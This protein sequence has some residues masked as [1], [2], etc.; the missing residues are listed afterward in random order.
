MFPYHQ[1]SAIVYTE[2]SGVFLIKNFGLEGDVLKFL[3]HS[4]SYFLSG[5]I[6]NNNYNLLRKSN[7]ILIDSRNNFSARKGERV[8]KTFKGENVGL[9][10]F[11]Q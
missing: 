9:L 3:R 1:K 8:L 10:V 7:N 5:T 2:Y 4:D 11:E 6:A